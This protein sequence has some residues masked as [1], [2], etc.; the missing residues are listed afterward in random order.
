MQCFLI[1]G[2]TGFVGSELVSSL[3]NTGYKVIGIGRKEQG[4]LSDEAKNHPS[5]KFYR[6]DLASDKLEY[7]EDEIN[8]VFHLASLQPDNS[9]LKFN[10]F[11]N[12]NVQ[13][14]LNIL[15]FCK[16]KKPY[17]MV[18]TSTTTV[19]EIKENGQIMYENSKCSPV[20]YY[21]ISKFTG[22]RLVETELKNTDTKAIIVRLP[23]LFGKNHKGGL[24]YT[25]FQE[26]L[27][28]VDIEIYGDG[29]KQRNLLYIEDVLQVLQGIINERQHL[30]QFEIFMAGSNNSLRMIDIAKGICRILHSN[31]NCI[32]VDKPT[33]PNIDILIDISKA[34]RV[35][36]YKPKNIE[37]NLSAYLKEMLNGS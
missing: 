21:G 8:G 37:E 7:I 22:E 18:Y 14:T 15:E 19:I 6:A 32:P 24:V 36:N 29:Q 3:L 4:F 23:S 11:Y 10:D 2:C 5:F 35:L 20:N 16:V 30:G 34:K 28:N 33:S 25:Y 13:T 27:K 17:F 26:A 9:Q 31:S 1:T 12:G